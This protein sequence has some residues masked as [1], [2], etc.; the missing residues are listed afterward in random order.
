MS[1]GNDGINTV[2]PYTDPLYALLRPSIAVPTGSVVPLSGVTGLHPAMT[3]LKPLYDAGK[4]AVIQGVGYP[5]MN[6]SHFRG[7][8]IWFSGSASEQIIETGWLGRFIEA[9]FPDFPGVMPDAP[10][11]LQQSDSHRLPLQGNRALAGV[12]VDDP[13][14]FYYLV[15]ENYPGSWSDPV[16]PTRGGQELTY[17]RELDRQTF[18]YAAAIQAASDQGSNSVA[19]PSTPLGSQ[20]EIVARLIS[21][22]LQTP[23]FLTTEYG[24]DTH[25]SQAANHPNLLASVADSM[26]SFW[27]DIQNQGLA[28]RVVLMTTSEFGRRVEENGSFGTDHGTAAPHFVLGS[29]VHGGL[30]GTNP[31][32]GNLDPNGNLFIQNDYRSLIGTVLSGH[33]GA[34]DSLL[35]GVFGAAYPKLGFLTDP[36]NISHGS[37]AGTADRLFAPSPNPARTGE[38]VE[39]RFDLAAD[40][41]VSLAVFDAQGRR[42]ATVVDAQRAAGS[43]R[44]E[45]DGGRLPAGTYLLRMET[46][47]RRRFAKISI[48]G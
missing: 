26:V 8:D 34:D 20:L 5:D 14:T 4:L 17:L 11:G 19:Y 2:I 6:L 31:N 9:T 46:S 47:T 37:G 40:S 15:N 33:F 35:E 3:S 36:A 18:G 12:V 27:S 28:D 32:L 44:V 38:R 23:V 10:Y 25:A 42:V 41:F 48:L 45:W 13:S 24:F 39:L 7:T 43:H 30:Y 29:N 22:G 16:P 1:G 21:G